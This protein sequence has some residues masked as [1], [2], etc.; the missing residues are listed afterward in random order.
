[1]QL[2]VEDEPDHGLADIVALAI[3]EM[4]MA[5]RTL[6]PKGNVDLEGDADDDTDESGEESARSIWAERL[7]ALGQFVVAVFLGT[8]VVSHPGKPLEVVVEELLG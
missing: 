2:V 6:K 8:H 3:E 1:M 4:I 5:A 7:E